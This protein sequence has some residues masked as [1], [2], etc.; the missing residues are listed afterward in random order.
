[1]SITSGFALLFLMLESPNV[2]EKSYQWF[3]MIG[4]T[5]AIAAG[6]YW[7]N[8]LYDRPIDRINRPS[9][10]LWVAVVGGRLL[11]SAVLLVW[12]IGLGMAILLPL[13]IFILHLLAIGGLAWYARWGKKTGLLGNVLIAG[14]TGIIPWEVMLLT[15]S[16]CYAVDWMIPLAIGYN[17]VRELIKDAED[18]AGDCVYGV[19]SLPSRLSAA[20]WN[21]LLKLLWTALIMLTF[22]PAI[23][24]K[25]LW[26][27]WPWL[28]LIIAGVG[29]LIPLL[30][31]MRFWG[32]YRVQSLLLKVAMGGGLV[33]LWGL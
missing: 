12:G 8:D 19:A 13:P 6:G 23:T 18:L 28:Y 10:A 1:M 31:G 30:L 20:T 17:F 29:S 22:M 21:M 32:N 7:L 25:V 4:S 33:A 14:L 24:A 16:T 3:L 5:V 2:R 27:E 11:L 9:R 15:G 26:G